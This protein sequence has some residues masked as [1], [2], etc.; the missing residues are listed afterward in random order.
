VGI[1]S[2]TVTGS[3]PNFTVNTPAKVSVTGG[4]LIYPSGL[5]Q[6]MGSY[7]N[8]SLLVAP[9]IVYSQQTGSLTLSNQPFTSPAYSYSYDI[10]PA[11]SNTNNIIQSG[12]ATNTVAINTPAALAFDISGSA[13]LAA[14]GTV[15]MSSSFTK[16]T[17]SSEIDV[18]VHTQASTGVGLGNFTFEIVLDGNISGISTSHT[19]NGST[20]SYITLKSVFSGI[21]AGTHTIGIRATPSGLG[22]LT[23]LNPNGYSARLILKETY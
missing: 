10:T 15:L 5:L 14:G 16:Q 18:F 13:L 17:A 12:P 4:A 2:A 23:T 3:A 1:G 6:V 7:P 9:S 20:T 22:V 8:Y 11:L 19:L 21:S